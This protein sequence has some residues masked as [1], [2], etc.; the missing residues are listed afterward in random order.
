MMH[1]HLRLKDE[2]AQ[3]LKKECEKSGI[4]HAGMV[5]L[6]LAEYLEGREKS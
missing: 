2:I 4:S 6:A 5:R 1:V 3:K